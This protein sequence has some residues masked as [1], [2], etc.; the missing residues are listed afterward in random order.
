MHSFVRLANG[1]TL[2]AGGHGPNLAEVT[3]DKKVVWKFTKDDAP[4]LGL[5]Y[6]AGFQ[7]LDDNVIIMSAY[8]SGVQ[9]FAIDKASK[10]VLWTVKNKEI[11]R[12]THVMVLDQTID[13]QS[14]KLK[15]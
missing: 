3:P 13:P 5:K 4:E 1:N 11:G 6:S 14:W 12:P 15:R 8:D 10:K 2:I 7:V 9:L